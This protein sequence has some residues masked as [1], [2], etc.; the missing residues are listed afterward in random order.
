MYDTE[1]ITASVVT[2]L[3]QEYI[4]ITFVTGNKTRMVV[5]ACTKSSQCRYTST[6]MPIYVLIPHIITVIMY[7]A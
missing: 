2:Y 6:N 3:Q 5:M 4:H 1:E 7:T